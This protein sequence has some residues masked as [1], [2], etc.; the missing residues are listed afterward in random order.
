MHDLCR[1][2][3]FQYAVAVV[4]CDAEVNIWSSAW[5]Y[6]EM[7]RVDENR[8]LRDGLGGGQLV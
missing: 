8:G 5:R 2:F 6:S 1:G 3:Q 4:T 7:A